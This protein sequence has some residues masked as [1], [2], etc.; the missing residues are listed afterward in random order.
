VKYIRRETDLP[1]TDIKHTAPARVALQGR[2][3]SKDIF[4]VLS[5]SGFKIRVWLQGF[6]ELSGMHFS[7]NYVS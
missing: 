5:K 6:R 3:V 4:K 7:K 2:I 1:S